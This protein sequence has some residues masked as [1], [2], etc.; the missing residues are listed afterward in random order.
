MTF[1]E[2]FKIVHGYDPF[3]WQ[4]K[5]ADHLVMG[6]PLSAVNV[7][8]A[9][10]KTAMIDAGVYAAA[11]G[12]ARRI[13]FIIDRR[14]VV[15][16]AYLRAQKIV[17][18]LEDTGLKSFADALGRVQI[19]RLRGGVHGDD[20]WVFY[21]DRVSVIIST[22]DQ[23]GSRLLH[24]GYGV[25]SRMHPVHAGFLGNDA[26]YIVDEAHIS[27]PF[28]QT[29]NW[30]RHYGADVR[31]ITMTATPTEKEGG[32]IELSTKDLSNPVLKKRLEASKRVRLVQ[33]SEEDDFTRES[34]FVKKAVSGAD[35]LSQ[36]AEVVCVLVNRVAT[37]R[38]IWESFAKQKR[39]AELLIGRIRPYDRDRL[40]E[41]LTPLV[42]AGRARKAGEPLFIIA[43]QT[44][45]VGAD[46]DFDA[47]VTES[48]SLS[49]LRQRFGRLDRLGEI[50]TTHGV[51]LYRPK[52][53]R[54]GELAPDSIYGNEI[55][56]SWEWLSGISDEGSVDFGI[57]A[58]SNNMDGDGVP[59]EDAIG[60]PVL[61]PTHMEMLAATGPDA[62][63]IDVSPWLHG[64][65]SGSADVSIVWRADLDPERPDL[66]KAT[67]RL[68]PP[69]T[70]EALEIPLY[71][72]LAWLEKGAVQ[73]V[74][75]LE[76]APSPFSRADS[77]S[78]VLRWRGQDD[79]EVVPS[80]EIRPGDTLVVPAAYGGSDAYGWAPRNR[81]LV[82]DVADLCSLERGRNHV[83]R[84]VPGL[85]GWLER[86]EALVL[87]V[88][89]EIVAAETAV[90][91]ETGVDEDRVISAHKELRD[92]I[93]QLDHP[94]VNIY[95]GQYEIERHPLRGVIL[96]GFVM[97]E[98]QASLNSGVPVELKRHLEN[99][100]KTAS[101]LASNHPEGEQ[102]IEAAELH[103]LGKSDFR[104]QIMLHGDPVSASAGP[105][106]AKSGLRKFSQRLAAYHASGLPKGFRHEV[107]SLEHSELK[108]DGKELPRHLI[109]SHH[110]YG[111]PW[112]PRCDAS[113]V[114]GVEYTL[115]GSV[116]AEQFIGLLKR[117]GYWGLA[118]MELLIRSA[119]VRASMVE[120]EER[121]IHVL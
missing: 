86:D 35:R 15:D 34:D 73:D 88:A 25:S 41:R 120:R 83:V 18:R 40:M 117:Y 30:A 66:W 43:T 96:R 112:F 107:G 37:A 49:A 59:K 32:T 24:R 115:L 5:A 27:T 69:L 106:L 54:K 89:E 110:G 9:S 119:D 95:K 104:F 70:R 99:V 22:V 4:I 23:V 12:G 61:L 82:E 58:M 81:S 103:D 77:S 51:I 33:S 45:E 14:V 74:S 56:Q 19:V 90:D 72:V 31:L 71:A 1:E 102:I 108:K 55:H 80:G 118:E 60:A 36:N 79:C 39:R 2:F 67:A 46:F 28:V 26:L 57:S 20:D 85:T 75:D 113:D 64:A 11:H 16:E 93:S 10:G 17:D 114:P 21:P 7:P 105:L 100:T 91:P 94:L 116:W 62:P 42:S 8:T 65:Q 63:N 98:M 68:S 78:S 47:L 50:G 97:D 92:L 29:V 121:K 3:P 53:D 48:A 101:Q 38:R 76:G 44:V 52:Y 87:E 84:L 109:A 13:A 6:E 111:R